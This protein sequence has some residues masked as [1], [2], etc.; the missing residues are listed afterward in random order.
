MFDPGCGNFRTFL[1]T[2]LRNFV[3]EDHRHTTTA[4]RG[5]ATA[6]RGS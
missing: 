1:K 5:G 4:K 3:R 2:V 6:H